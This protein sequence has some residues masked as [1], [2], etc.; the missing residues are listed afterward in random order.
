MEITHGKR[1]SKDRA[2][3]VSA[4]IP[5]NVGTGIASRKLGRDACRMSD[6]RERWLRKNVRLTPD[7]IG[8]VWT[9]FPLSWRRAPVADAAGVFVCA[10][11]VC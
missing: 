2:E 9:V 5:Q 11:R 3:P 7:E 1:P 8:L 6:R 4:G 10:M